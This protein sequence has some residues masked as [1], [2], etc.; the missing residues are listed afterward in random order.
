MQQKTR[1]II[2]TERREEAFTGSCQ[3]LLEQN[4]LGSR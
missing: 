2:K 3:E 1:L 4:G